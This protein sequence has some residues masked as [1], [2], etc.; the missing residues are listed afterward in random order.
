MWERLTPADLDRAKNRLTTSRA[1]MLRRHA[2]ELNAL[3][4]QQDEIETLER[5]M[6]AFAHRYLSSEIAASM[7]AAESPLEQANTAVGAADPDEGA[8]AEIQQKEISM[9]LRVQ[10]EISSSFGTP[11]RLRRLI[12]G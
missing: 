3:D 2:A 7:P 1:E 5:L 8:A 9:D 10:Q 11:P 12:G 6:A 4:A